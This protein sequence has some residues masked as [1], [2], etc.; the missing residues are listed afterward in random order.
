LPNSNAPAITIADNAA[1]ANNVPMPVIE[2][3][4]AVA[5]IVSAD[6][7]TN[8]LKLKNLLIYSPKNG[9]NQ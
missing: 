2:N 7:E 4:A 6:N 3:N 1:P 5:A 9:P 8:V